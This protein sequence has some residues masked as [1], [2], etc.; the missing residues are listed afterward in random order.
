MI[1][2][3]EKISVLNVLIKRIKI[4]IDSIASGGGQEKLTRLR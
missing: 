4:G 2:I 3:E 1:N